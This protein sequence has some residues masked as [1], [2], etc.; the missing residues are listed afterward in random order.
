MVQAAEVIKVSHFTAWSGGE[1]GA[2]GAVSAGTAGSGCAVEI[3]VRALDQRRAGG[4]VTRKAVN[5]RQR[6]GWGDFEDRAITVVDAVGP[7]PRCRS[8][9]VPVAAFNQRKCGRL[10]VGASAILNDGAEG[11]QRGQLAGSGHLE[12]RS[13]V[14]KAV[15]VDAT[16]LRSPVKV[17]IGGLNQRSYGNVVAVGV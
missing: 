14:T 10:A 6:T 8:V 13:A 9:Q 17:P 11:V 3:P 7:A 12:D 16:I 5:R 15:V 1:K 4:S 2:S